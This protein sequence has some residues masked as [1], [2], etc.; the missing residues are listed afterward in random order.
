MAKS[1]KS[2]EK[3]LKLVKS[4]EKL[5]KVVKSGKSEEKWLKVT[6][7]GE[8]LE[9]V[10][11]NGKKCEKW[12]KVW[13]SWKKWGKVKNRKSGEKWLKVWK[14]SG[15]KFTFDRNSGSIQNWFFSAA[16]F[17]VR[18]SLSITFLAISDRSA[19]LD[20]QQLSMAEMRKSGEKWD[21][22]WKSWKKW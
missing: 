15:E 6:K 5:E 16:I 10:G 7:S 17:D 22:V 3:W 13:K 20:V 2:C 18:K 11:G 14:K 8:K 9:K 4:G 1:G 21:K 12:E 19:I